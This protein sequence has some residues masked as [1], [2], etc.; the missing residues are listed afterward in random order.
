[1]CPLDQDVEDVIAQ[2]ADTD[3]TEHKHH[4]MLQQGEHGAVEQ[5]RVMTKDRDP[6]SHSVEMVIDQL[7][8]QPSNIY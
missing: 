1:M 8:L 7:Y 5:D 4:D 2:P 3:N 6:R